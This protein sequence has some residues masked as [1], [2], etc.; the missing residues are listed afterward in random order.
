M[1]DS[2]EVLKKQGQRSTGNSVE[3]K[4]LTTKHEDVQVSVNLSMGNLGRKVMQ[5]RT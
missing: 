5:K 4:T 1:A 2:R 3:E